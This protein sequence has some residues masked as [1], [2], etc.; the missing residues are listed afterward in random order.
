MVYYIVNNKGIVIARSTVTRMDPEEYD[1]DETK[2]RMTDLNTV[3]KS[4]IGDYRKASN[5]SNIMQ[6]IDETT[7][8]ANY[9][10]VLT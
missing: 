2:D 4:S 9:C 3:I 7:L 8:S 1:V 5:E 10:T 6:K